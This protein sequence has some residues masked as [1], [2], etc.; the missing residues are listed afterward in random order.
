MQMV[1]QKD[2]GIDLEGVTRHHVPKR[3]S[4]KRDVFRFTQ[5]PPPTVCHQCK[6]VGP[7]LRSR[8]SVFHLADLVTSGVLIQEH[9]G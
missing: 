8:S 4:Q 1:R 5:E 3:P 9:P 6:E 2:E 7:A